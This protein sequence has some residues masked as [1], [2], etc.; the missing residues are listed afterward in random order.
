VFGSD[1]A[2][3]VTETLCFRGS[4][5]ARVILGPD[6]VEFGAMGIWVFKGRG[7]RWI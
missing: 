5:A 7:L 1:G 3:V 4:A 6:V 2:P